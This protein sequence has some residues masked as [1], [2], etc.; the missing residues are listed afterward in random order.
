MLDDDERRDAAEAHSLFELLE[1]QI[2]PLFYDRRGGSPRGWLATMKHAFATLGPYVTASRQVRDYVTELYEPAAGHDTRLTADGLA[3]ARQ[4][5][6]WKARV[7]AGWHGVHVD[8]IE[9]STDP[10]DVGTERSVSAVVALGE[11]DPG[12]V[13]V[14]LVRGRVVGD[15]ELADPEIVVMTPAGPVDGDHHALRGLV[16]LRARRAGRCDR[17]GR[18]VEPTA[19]HRRGARADRL[20]VSPL[21]PS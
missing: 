3:P 1:H 17:P 4:L 12:D 6:A 21:A 5:A 19:R 20:G 7:L 10:T 9:A 14:Q 15:D 13:E 11:L 2:V 8:A 18:S 16:H